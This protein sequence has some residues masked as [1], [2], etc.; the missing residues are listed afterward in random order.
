M[1]SEVAKPQI[2]PRRRGRPKKTTIQQLA[3]FEKEREEREMQTAMNNPIRRQFQTP[4]D[5]LID[6]ALGRYCLVQNLR[7][8]IF[9]SASDYAK[10]RRKIISAWG[11][12]LA[13]QPNGTGSDIDLEIVHGWER[14]VSD[15][16]L[17][18]LESSIEGVAVLGWIGKLT[19]DDVDIAPYMRA[20][21]INQGLLALA[22]AMGRLDKRAL[23]KT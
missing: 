18:I 10:T 5:P 4:R 9:D 13:D 2:S 16:E 1:A 12:P 14:D 17:A 23:A 8:E 20:F 21:F 11:G 15:W 7:R 22:V 3:E 19:F 6:S